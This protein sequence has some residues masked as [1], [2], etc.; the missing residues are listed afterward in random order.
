MTEGL[1]LMLVGMG[2]VFVFLTLLV[3]ITTFMSK[4]IT[5]YEKNVGVLPEEGIPAPTAVISQAMSAKQHAN[6][7]KNLITIL[8]AAVHKFRS[9]HK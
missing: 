5:S 9:R 8:S 2:F 4:I 1:N 3:I 7:D 6:D